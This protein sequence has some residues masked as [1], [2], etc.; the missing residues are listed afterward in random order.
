MAAVERF[1]EKVLADNRT[2]PYF[3]G[4]SMAAQTQKQVAFMAWAFGGPAEYKGRDL[5]EAHAKL[6]KRGLGNVEF[7]AVKGHLE[8]TLREIGVSDELARE[9]LSVVEG[10]RDHVLGRRR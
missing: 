5:A 9:A 8:A 1:Y 2:R 4:L 6:V 7:D 3:A 10:T